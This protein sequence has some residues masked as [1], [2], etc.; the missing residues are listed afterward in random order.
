[1]L[2]ADAKAVVV[3][4]PQG[5]AIDD[6]RRSVT[7][8]G[9]VGNTVLGIVENMSGIVCSQCGHVENIF[10]KGGGMGLAQELGVR[11]LGEIPL[12]PEVVRS[13]DEGYSFSYN[14]V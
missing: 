3:T 11:F 4:T 1:M 9:D 6:V 13:G 7:F 5:V 12:D 14:F 10:G 2:G 8:V